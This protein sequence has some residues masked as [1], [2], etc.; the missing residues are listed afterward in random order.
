MFQTKK[1]LI[2]ISVL[3]L[4]TVIPFLG[5][6]FLFQQSTGVENHDVGILEIE[7]LKDEI[8][9]LKEQNKKQ[10]EAI[11]KM[12]PAVTKSTE[13]S[14][15]SNFVPDNNL[16]TVVNEWQRHVAH[17]ECNWPLIGGGYSVARGSGFFWNAGDNDFFALSNL[18][19][20]VQDDYSG[21][22][23]IPQYCSIKFPKDIGTAIVPGKDIYKVSRDGEVQIDA[24][25][26]VIKNPTQFM[27]TYPVDSFIN[28]GCT[29]KNS[30]ASVGDQL[31][32]LG[33]PGIGS[34]T[35][36]TATEG[37]VS[38]FDGDFYITSA[39]VEHGNSG[40]IAIL[41][42][43]NCYLGIPT[44]VDVGQIESLARILDLDVVISAL[45]PR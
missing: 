26:I 42:K 10:E 15:K 23:T 11:K 41:I 33:Y 22:S 13:I 8:D 5:Y 16:S 18:H 25:L 19:V 30:V 36:V 39:K 9:K 6:K 21:K 17:I 12:P 3:L 7:K 14:P 2:I 37:I 29:L 38:G 35:G 45:A 31:V 24:S 40:G 28:K 27:T 44:F 1:P 32:I 34:Q 43:D 4:L 20:V